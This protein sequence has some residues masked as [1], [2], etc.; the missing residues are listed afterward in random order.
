[1]KPD[2]DWG[3]FSDMNLRATGRKDV[4]AVAGMNTRPIDLSNVV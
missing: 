4:P 2:S 3:G 1:M